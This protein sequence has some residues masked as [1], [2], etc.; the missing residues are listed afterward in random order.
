[1]KTIL[2]DLDGTLTDSKRGIVNCIRYA[3]D[4]LERPCPD[5]LDWCIGPPLDGALGILLETDDKDAIYGTLNIYR[6][7]FSTIGLFENDLYPDIAGMLEE[8]AATHDLYV[9]TAKPW[10]FAERII[11]HFG[12][13]P[14]FIKTYGAELD[15][16]RGD[17]GELIAYILEQE[18]LD[19][20]T[21][22]MVGD[23]SHDLIGARKNNVASVGVLWGYGG[24]A[25]LEAH[26]PRHLAENPA[27][28]T[29]YL[30]SL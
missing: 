30:Q 8:L 21:T 10:V 1:M 27:Q 19:P 16:T 2:F 15:C 24:R 6:E 13:T 7:R 26:E 29:T 20:A 17:K 25:E 4:K 18:N 11:E 12:L 5:D 14:H 9:A 3:M 23:R 22:I 28:L